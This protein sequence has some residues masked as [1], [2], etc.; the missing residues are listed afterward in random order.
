MDHQ[1]EA[2]K[3]IAFQPKIESPAGR[4]AL[5]IL[6]RLR[7]AGHETYLVGGCVRDLL[8]GVAPEDYDLA[9]SACPEEIMKLFPR[10]VAVGASFGVVMVLSGGKSHEV[11]TFR[12]DKI[13]QDGRR[14]TGVVFA[15]PEEDVR[16][17]DFTV[18]ALLL[19]PVAGKII[20]HV[21]GWQDLETKTLRAIGSAR[22]R[23]AEDHLRMLRA[24]RLACG[25]RFTL[26]ET[27]QAA[28]IDQAAKI[29]RISAERIRQEMT[30][31]LTQGQPQQGLKLLDSTDLL[32]WILPEVAALKGI[33][34]PAEYHPAGDAWEHTL[35]IMDIYS[36]Q[37]PETSLQAREI[38]AWAALL[39]DIG[40]AKTVTVVEKGIRFYGHAQE[41]AKMAQ[42]ILLRLRFPSLFI[43]TVRDL[44]FQHM[45]F[46]EVTKMR[47][48]RLKRFLR[49]DIFPLLLELYRLDCLA[50]HGKLGTYEFCRRHLETFTEPEIK[51][52]PLINGHDLKEWGL[53]PGPLFAE[54][55][56]AV[57]DAQLENRIA[58]RE[59]ARRFVLTNWKKE[60]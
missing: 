15:G 9:T 47:T 34:Q 19:D 53:A 17:R 44:V 59:E 24:I 54:I 27:T 2:P 12:A 3:I 18:N 42:E 20:D 35:K 43:I 22:E 13:Y 57:E 25:L 39:H 7:K 5:D 29:R 60:R 31:I 21:G 26:E 50:S 45:Q 37:P 10:T 40:K 38:L 56:T 11:A 49:Q 52:P 8:R 30:K 16:R 32:S 33:D 6:G 28:I 55:L 51:P 14:P 58:D 23:F 48:S 36:H 4:A 46:L 41:G 1:P